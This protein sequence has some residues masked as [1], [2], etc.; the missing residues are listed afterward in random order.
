MRTRVV[1][2]VVAVIAGLAVW[3]S[4]PASADFVC[5]SKITGANIAGN[6]TVPGTAVCYIET[7]TIT[8]NIT[9]APG[10][11]LD[12][13]DRSTVNGSVI[14][15]SPGDLDINNSTVKGSL[16]INGASGPGA[17][18]NFVLCNNNFSSVTLTGLSQEINFGDTD[19]VAINAVAPCTA[20]GGNHLSGSLR[21][22]NNTNAAERI[23]GNTVAGSGQVT[24]NNSPNIRNNSFGGALTCSNNGTPHGSG[25]TASYISCP[26]AP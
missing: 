12:E 26:L 10:G 6:V 13:L 15:N 23:Q 20:G 22:A 7:S 24:G 17:S 8:G 18:I 5:T 25:N 1:A 14:G 4:S 9:V 2:I 21:F 19:A 3:N 16:M 11:W